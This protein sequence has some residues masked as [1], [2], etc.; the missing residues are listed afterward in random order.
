MVLSELVKPKAFNEKQFAFNRKQL[1]FSIK[2][3]DYKN[4]YKKQQMQAK[5]ENLIK[6]V[7]RNYRSH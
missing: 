4:D 1:R 3:D 7:R 6:K 5:N 2:Q